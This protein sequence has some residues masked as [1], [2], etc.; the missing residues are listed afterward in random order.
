MIHSDLGSQFSSGDWQSFLK[1]NKLLGSMSRRGNYHGN[2]V[3][4][5]FFQLLKR[6]RIWRKIYSIRQE[7]RGDV[8]DYTKVFYNPK[9]RHDFNNQQSPVALEKRHLLSLEVPR[10]SEAIQFALSNLW[11]ARRYL[12][13]TAGEVRLQYGK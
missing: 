2:A 11:M 7:A 6:E 13:T 10:K 8:F 3:A 1:A 9:R 5:S 4:E 12:L